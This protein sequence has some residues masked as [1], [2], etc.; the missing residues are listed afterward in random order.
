MRLCNRKDR[1]KEMRSQLPV[2]RARCASSTLST[3]S[4]DLLMLQEQLYA[5]TSSGVVWCGVVWCDEMWCDE[6]WCGVMGCGV[7]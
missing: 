4:R 6:M 2:F 1:K 7:V 3:I 5:A